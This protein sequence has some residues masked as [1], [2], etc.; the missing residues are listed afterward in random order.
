MAFPDVHVLLLFVS[1][2]LLAFFSVIK[3]PVHVILNHMY[4]VLSC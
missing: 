4:A 2:A 3:L 1:P